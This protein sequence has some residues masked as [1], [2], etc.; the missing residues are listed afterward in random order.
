MTKSAISVLVSGVYF[1]GQGLL[2][3]LFPDFLLSLFGIPSPKDYWVRVVG[4]A[5]IVFAFYY[6]RNAKA[7]NKGFFKVSAQGRVLQF[8][9]FLVLYFLYSIP[10]M[11]VGFS[12]IELCSGLWTIWA[13]KKDENQ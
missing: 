3:F 9:L 13:L 7:D 5:L 11:V 2:L 10:L 4:L 8:L 1:L 6:I 12:A